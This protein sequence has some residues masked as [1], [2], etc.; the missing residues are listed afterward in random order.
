[1]DVKIVPYPEVATRH[2]GSI[3]GKNEQEMRKKN[4]KKEIR[5]PHV[6]LDRFRHRFLMIWGVKNGGRIMKN[7]SR[8]RSESEN[9]DFS[10]IVFPCAREHRLVVGGKPST[11]FPPGGLVEQIS[12]SKTEVLFQ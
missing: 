7:R 1:M 2:L 4:E 10:E 12:A 3:F 11:W 6:F 8:R 9:G 5:K